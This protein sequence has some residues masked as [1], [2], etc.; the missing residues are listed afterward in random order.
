M[1]TITPI[2]VSG[3]G[4]LLM[5]ELAALRAEAAF[6]DVKTYIQSGN[7]VFKTRLSEAKARATLEKALSKKLGVPACA[8]LRSAEQLEK[9]PAQNPFKEHPPNRMLIL[10]MG[11]APA[12]KAVKAVV[13]PDGE[14][15]HLAGHDLL[16]Y[17]PNGS[18]R[19]KLTLPFIKTCTSRNINTVM[20][21]AAML[22]HSLT[23]REGHNVEAVGYE[24]GRT[25]A[26]PENSRFLTWLASCSRRM[27]PVN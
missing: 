4:K 23:T 25:Q 27:L 3:T 13:S 16:I 20:K 18:G 19:L 6:T 12:A 26:W 15:L 7:V 17:Y 9:L 5:S 2:N 1:R 21:P 10:F 11:E 22:E 14:Q 24:P 8:V